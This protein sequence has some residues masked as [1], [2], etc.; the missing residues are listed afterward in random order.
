MNRPWLHLM[1]VVFVL[2]GVL[3]L[4][5]D[6]KPNVRLDA[7]SFTDLLRKAQRG[8]HRAQNRVGLAYARGEVVGL[9]SS[10]AVRWFL[11]AAIAGDPYAQ[12]N[13]GV[14]LYRGRGVEHN[15]AE[16][17]TWFEKAAAKG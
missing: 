5:A 8:E 7:R 16:A 6:K 3:S 13:L 10:E 12:H 17:M 14:M 2:T 4:A 1:G 11:K 15:P 9:N